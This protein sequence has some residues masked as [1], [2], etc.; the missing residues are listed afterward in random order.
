MVLLLKI[1]RAC[2]RVRGSD[3]HSTRS[4]QHLPSPSPV[5]HSDGQ[6]RPQI[7]P[8][9][10]SATERRHIICTKV[11]ILEW[12]IFRMRTVQHSQG[13]VNIIRICVMTEYR[14]GF[15]ERRTL[16]YIFLLEVGRTKAYVHPSPDVATT[17]LA[18]FLRPA[19]C[20]FFWTQIGRPTGRGYAG[21]GWTEQR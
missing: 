3:L 13:E 17:S 18:I 8:S 19:V 4:D 10:Q 16:Y 15:D 11:S 1:N 20:I 6:P 9:L 5:K 2:P 14:G 7:L 21:E 12:T